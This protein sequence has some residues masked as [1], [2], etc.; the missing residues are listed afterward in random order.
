[1][2][3]EI[4]AEDGRAAQLAQLREWIESARERSYAKNDKR[5]Y[6]ELKYDGSW[7]I[8]T[9]GEAIDFVQ[10]ADDGISYEMRDKW[11]TPQ[12]YDKL[13]EFEGF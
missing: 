7:V 13:P 5:R 4:P 3:N 1:M 6:V 11:L 9:P 2:A 10:D 12:Q 8:C